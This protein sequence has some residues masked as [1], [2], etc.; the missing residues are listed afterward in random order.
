MSTM[1]T[2]IISN[3]FSLS[4]YNLIINIVLIIVVIL[5]VVINKGSGC[6]AKRKICC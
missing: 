3:A 2:T 1:F 4:L 6:T 5:T